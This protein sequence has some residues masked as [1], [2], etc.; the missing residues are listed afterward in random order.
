VLV[1]NAGGEVCRCPD[2]EESGRDAEL[3]GTGNAGKPAV[4]AAV[5]ITS[6]RGGGEY[7]LSGGE[8]E[9]ML[10]R[11]EGGAPGEELHWF[12]DGRPAGVSRSGEPL[13]WELEKGTHRLVVAAESGGES[14]L[15]FT[16]AGM[17]DGAAAF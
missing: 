13:E 15:V 4:R 5:A 2:G 7:V 10:L 17:P 3:A 11:A 6:P 9:Q 8:K 1:G 16:V 14:A 12:V